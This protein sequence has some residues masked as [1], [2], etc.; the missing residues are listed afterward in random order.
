[1][2][3][4]KKTN[5]N[6][7]IQPLPANQFIEEYKIINCI[8]QGGFG[9]TYLCFDEN[10][11]RKCVIKE[12]TPHQIAHR[13]IS[14][15]IISKS[16]RFL[17]QFTIGK[18]DFLQEAQRLALFSHP[19][20]VR[21]NRFFEAN[22]T[23][24]F[25]MDYVEGESLRQK[26][27]RRRTNFEEYEIEAILLPL[28]SGLNE[29][30]KKG[31]IHRDIKPENIII[32]SD[33]TPLLIDFGAVGNLNAINFEEY[34]IYI[35]PYY[36]PFEQY[37]PDFPQGPW[38]DIYAIGATI[39]ELI[40]GKPPQNPVERIR[41]DNQESAEYIGKGRISTKLLELVDKS[42]S[43][44]YLKRPKNIEE[45][46]NFLKNDKYKLIRLII[47][48]ASGKAIQHFL[49][50]A[51]PNK[52]LYVDEF[53]SFVVGF[54]ILELTWRLNKGRLMDSGLFEKLINYEMINSLQVEF[55]ESGFEVKQ[56]TL[57]LEKIKARL[58]EYAATYFLDREEEEW[59]YK[60]TRDRCAKNCIA[61]EYKND[62]N[63]FKELMEDVIDR[64]R[65]RIKKEIEKIYYK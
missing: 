20:I 29:L 64:Y 37:S 61:P 35:T 56:G 8:G 12:F 24:Y 40:A 58:E 45:F 51:K 47:H 16:K 10:L 48:S 65:G 31:F 59:S 4:R 44:D 17:D 21:V 43:I 62:L 38:I 60:L 28:C 5:Q 6:K 7:F 25:V 49:N 57:T 41:N 33:G 13:E 9:T 52:G 18:N 30:H 42:L 14:L 50:F 46:I 36:A 32:K 63:G 22:N 54:S 34:K 26:L 23:G 11:K 15:N 27:L 39:F 3:F 19:N 2:K 1:M 55:K 53:V